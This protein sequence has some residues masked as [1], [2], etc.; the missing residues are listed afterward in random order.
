MK[1]LIQILLAVC[2][3]LPAEL[4]A[5]RSKSGRDRNAVVGL[6]G[7]EGIIDRAGG[8]HNK[9]NIGAFF[10]N[11]GKLYAHTLSQGVSG[12][13]PLGSLHEY[14]YR[15]NSYV[16]FPANVIQGRFTNNEE[17]EAVPGYN[18]RDSAKIAMSD[19]PTTW[20]KTGW[21]VKDA[22]GNN[23][24]VSDQ[25]S[26]CVYCDSNSQKG[27]RGIQINQTGYAFNRKG[28]RD[29]IYFIF[30][31]T[32][33]SKNTYDSLY[34]GFYMDCDVGG[35][36]TEYGDDRYVFDKKWGRVYAYDVDGWSDEWNGPTAVFGLMM[37]RTPKVNGVE[38]GITDLHW[39]TY[40]DDAINDDNIEFGRMAST[41][42]LYQSA[43]GPKYFHLPAG[44]TDIHFDDFSLMPAAG[45]DP[46]TILSSGPYR[47]APG[48]TLKFVTAMVAG[49]TVEELDATTEHA[50]S[51]LANYF[52]L[53]QPPPSPKIAV[54]AG[55][56]RVSV[57]W[58]NR[59]ETC[60][61]PL[62]GKANFESYSLFKSI[63][64]GVHWD[65]ID[66]NLAP[67]TGADPVP[68]AMYDRVD[69]FGKET[70]L[71]YS[72][73]DTNVTNG[74]EYWYTLTATSV[75]DSGAT[76]LE[77]SRGATPEDANLGTAVPRSAALG[78]IPVTAS[79]PTQSGSGTS[80]V[81]FDIHALDSPAAGGRTYKIEFAPLAKIELGNLEPAITLS[82]VANGPRSSETFALTFLSSTTFILRN[83][84]EG[85]IVQAAGT[86][87]S[88]VPILFE[89]LSL[90]LTDTSHVLNKQPKEGDSLVIGQGIRVTAGTAGVVSLQPILSLQPFSYG[91]SYTM[92]SGV[93]FAIRLADTLASSKLT[94]LDIYTFSTS[95]AGAERAISD[96]DLDRVKVVPNP[97]L[98]ASQYEPEFGTLRRE[99]VRL[100]KFNNLPARCTIYIFNMVGDKIQTIEHNSDNGTESWNLR[101]AGNRE[102]APGIYLYLVK[103]DTAEKIGRF[104]VIK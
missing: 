41:Q 52:Q 57:T 91:T 30:E 12:E 65:Q 88:G 84:T 29:L 54:T 46:V 79:V 98:V 73:I 87:Q 90:T 92:V 8:K 64:K 56:R 28:V 89:G 100:L 25:D 61:D 81:L 45:M 83:L 11:R 71:Q 63:D 6:P 85:T 22:A 99:P 13:F 31:I 15:V 32:N 70:G 55:D 103:T 86:Y 97:Y 17:W 60:R 37:M 34:F 16:G 93:S 95:A 72:Y 59:S 67:N 75:F 39:C 62:T 23:V 36:D 49:N 76:L 102:I 44:A 5:Q 2:L 47:I 48:D 104:A 24:F 82:V 94:Y 20:P 14:I 58:D 21:P 51:L 9:S 4:Q 74:F 1:T 26:Y 43:N 10:E 80:H 33:F 101:A 27:K 40:D 53:P 69:G 38:L 66:R 35:Y 3:I 96:D 78:R 42:A 77:S 68:L 7:T 50:Y 19:K 18:N